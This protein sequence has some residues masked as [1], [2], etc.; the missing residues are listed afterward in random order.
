MDLRRFLSGQEFP[1]IAGPRDE[2]AENVSRAHEEA[3]LGEK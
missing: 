2:S 1:K 3:D